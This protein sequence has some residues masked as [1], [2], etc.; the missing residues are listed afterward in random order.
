[1][2]IN[3]VQPGT[4]FTLVT[5]KA[6]VPVYSYLHIKASLS[7]PT[8]YVTLACLLSSTPSVLNYTTQ[9]QQQDANFAFDLVRN[10]EM[11]KQLVPPALRALA[12][13]APRGSHGGGG[14]G[15]GGS[16]AFSRAGIGA[17]GVGG[18]G[19]GGFGPS[20]HHQP[21]HHPQRQGQAVG[22]GGGGRGGGGY[23]A[24]PPPGAMGGGGGGG[25]AFVRPVDAAQREFR[26]VGGAG[27]G[28]GGGSG[29]GSGGGGNGEQPKRKSRWG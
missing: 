8:P 16:H 28:A 20:S 1:M 6:R 23:R 27:M 3:G 2:G 5:Q 21:G 19:G 11:S 26:T 22:G 25:I 4:A 10:L 12:A 24:V 15:G 17:G 9:F 7:H 18:G 29:G 14:G 13:R